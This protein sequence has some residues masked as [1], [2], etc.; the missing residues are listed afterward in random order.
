MAKRTHVH[1]KV[2]E[3]AVYPTQGVAEVT[4]LEEKEIQGQVLRF[5]ALRLVDTGL[6]ILVPVDKAEHVGLRPVAGERQV[7]E[8]YAVLGERDAPPDKQSWNRRY[9]G[10]MD[11]LKTG[12]LPEVA[13][14]YRD[15]TRLKSGGKNLSFGERKMLDHARFLLLKELALVR[16]AQVGPLEK[17]LE[18]LVAA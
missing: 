11:K 9:R 6:K 10:F 3:K 18:R 16:H 14:V 5:Y 1:F 8:V 15:L 2:G 4:G 7:C 12:A 13:E 17:E